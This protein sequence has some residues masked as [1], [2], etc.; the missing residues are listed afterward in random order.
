M[1]TERPYRDKETKR[2]TIDEA[3]EELVKN[4]GTQFNPKIVDTFI[5]IIKENPNIFSKKEK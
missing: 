4:K 1:V 5:E 2:L 3:V